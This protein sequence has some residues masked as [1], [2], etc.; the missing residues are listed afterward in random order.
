[1]SGLTGQKARVILGCACLTFVTLGV[2]GV[3]AQQA[4][5]PTGPGGGDRSRPTEAMLNACVS[6]QRADS[7]TV[8]NGSDTVAGTCRAPEG[9]LLACVPNRTGPGGTGGPRPNQ[10]NSGSALPATQAYTLGVLCDLSGSQLNGQLGLTSNFLWSCANGRRSLVANGIPGHQV[11]VFPNASNPN[12]ISEQRVAF[13]TSLSPVAHSGP[14]GPAKEAVMGL[15]GVKFDPATAGTCSDGISAASRCRLAPGGGGSWNI[16]ALGQD[17]FDFGEDMNNAHVQPG[18]IY[19]YHGVPTGLLSQAARDGREMALVGWAADGFPVYARYG[20]TGSTQISGQLRMM[21][22]SY[23]L[24]QAAD[25]GRPSPS[26]IPMG[27]FTQDW[28]YVA[29]LGDLD[30]CNGRFGTTPEF[31][32]GIYHYYTTDSYPYV[33]RCVKGSLEFTESPAGARQGN[34]RRGEG[35]RGGQRRPRSR[36]R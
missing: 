22:T 16:E 26:I 10:S 35:E 2:A 12:P 29:G 6:K 19:H 1:M 20:F 8:Q 27:A 25:P 24:K 3:S 15:N 13:S 14:G 9:R 4:Q 34:G 32:G 5:S 21:E 36:D 18:G 17:S 7:C 11:G 28:E 33:Q 30:E 31:P 23:R